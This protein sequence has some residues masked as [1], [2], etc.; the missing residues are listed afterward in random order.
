MQFITLPDHDEQPIYC[1]FCGKKVVD[2]E[3][4]QPITLCDHV[5]TLFHIE[6]VEYEADRSP[7]DDRGD[8]H[9]VREQ[10]E[11]VDMPGAFGF[12]LGQRLET[13]FY[14]VFAP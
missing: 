13:R 9:G 5:L 4:D 14:L 8:E 2:L 10:W 11:Q 1:P 7:R 3:S 12:Q 6:G